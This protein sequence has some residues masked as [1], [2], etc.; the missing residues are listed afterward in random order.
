M[1]WLSLLLLFMLTFALLAAWIPAAIALGLASLDWLLGAAFL[2]VINRNN[3]ID[4]PSSRG[5]KPPK[6]GGQA[7]IFKQRAERVVEMKAA[8]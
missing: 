2:L 5:G 4:P 7:A 8:A 3:N 6:S 1:N